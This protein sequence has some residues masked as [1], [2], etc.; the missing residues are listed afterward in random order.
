MRDPQDISLQR[1]PLH[2][3]ISEKY[4]FFISAFEITCCS[5]D[6]IPT[7][8]SQV[9]K[10]THGLEGNPL[11]LRQSE[12]IAF[13]KWASQLADKNSSSGGSCL[14]SEQCALITETSS[15]LN[16][17]KSNKVNLST[18]WDWARTK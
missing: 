9:D 7:L 12:S 2:F 16:T 14:W 6:G 17:K 5:L 11:E 1:S 15:H 10:R 3:H 4:Q 18:S 8:D 13:N